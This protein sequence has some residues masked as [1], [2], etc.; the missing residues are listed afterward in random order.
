M[1]NAR[2]LIAAAAVVAF[3]EGCGGTARHVTVG[4]GSNASR[5]PA[6]IA[7]YGCAACHTIAGIGSSAQVGPELKD[8]SQ[9]RYIAGRLANTPANLV[10][11]IREPQQVDP[12]NV[13]P[14]LGVTQHD[15]RDIAAYLYS[16]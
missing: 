4:A 13:M 5:A 6:E 12:G 3:A 16:H 10:E 9:R 11:W 2:L 8:F 7:R 15:A 1:R 14:T